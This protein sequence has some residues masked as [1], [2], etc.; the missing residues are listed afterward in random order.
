MAKIGLYLVSILNFSL[1][2]HKRHSKKNNIHKFLLFLCYKHILLL[3][4]SPAALDDTRNFRKKFMVVSIFESD[5]LYL[6]SIFEKSGL[7]LVSNRDFL[8]QGPELSS[9]KENDSV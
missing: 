7:F 2:F 5:G 8:L 3:K 1:Y 9:L 4:F 6:V